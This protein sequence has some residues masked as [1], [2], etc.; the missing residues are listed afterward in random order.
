MSESTTP[1]G[2]N[3]A[4][5]CSDRFSWLSIPSTSP[6]IPLI[7]SVWCESVSVVASATCFVSCSNCSVFLAA[8]IVF[9]CVYSVSPRRE[10]HLQRVLDQHVTSFHAFI[11]YA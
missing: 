4:H 11:L 7:W 3:A 9:P 5:T 1:S 2:G 8:S 10:K 6:F